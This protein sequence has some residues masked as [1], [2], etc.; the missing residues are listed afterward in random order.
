MDG[1]EEEF[2]DGDEVSGKEEELGH[3]GEVDEEDEDEEEEESWKGE[4]RKRTRLR[5][6][7]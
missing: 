2:D 5:R 4:K 6:R 3:D 7:R 1:E